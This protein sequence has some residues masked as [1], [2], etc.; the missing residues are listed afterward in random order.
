MGLDLSKN[1]PGIT[2]YNITTSK[3]V[4]CDAIKIPSSVHFEKKEEMEFLSL[5]LLEFLHEYKPHKVILEEVFMSGRTAKSNI[6]LI[7]LN[8]FIAP[9]LI[10]YGVQ[11]MKVLPAA[12][13]AYLKIKPNKK[14]QGFKHIQEKYPELNL[15]NFEKENDK[16]DS[17]ILALNHDNEQLEKW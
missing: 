16:S 12:S 15:T 11:L 14:E 3:I 8:G 4:F 13:R 6:P 5:L 9:I 10:N 7:R 1:K 17:M 2:I